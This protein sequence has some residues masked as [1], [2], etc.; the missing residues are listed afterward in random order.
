MILG[1]SDDN[2]AD[3]YVVLTVSQLL[4]VYPGSTDIVR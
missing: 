1:H 3:A 4:P 2:S